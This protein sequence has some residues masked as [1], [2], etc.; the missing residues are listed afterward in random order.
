MIDVPKWPEFNI[1]NLQKMTK[2]GKIIYLI[3]TSNNSLNNND[4]KKKAFIR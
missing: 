4:I 3:G 2:D 1:V